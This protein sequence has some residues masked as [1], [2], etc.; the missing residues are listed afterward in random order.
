MVQV[1]RKL[2][3][4]LCVVLSGIPSFGSPLGKMRVGANVGKGQMKAA[5]YALVPDIVNKNA[6]VGGKRIGG[7][8][9]G[10][11]AATPGP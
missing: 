5:D 8:L 1:S 9:G 2:W 6:N 10:W 4:P 7:I 3:V 11:R